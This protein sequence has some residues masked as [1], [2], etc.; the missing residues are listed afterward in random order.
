MK[1]AFF[2]R[3]LA[4]IAGGAERAVIALAGAMAERGHRVWIVTHE[5]S[6]A[7]P[8]YPVPETV[9]LVRLGKQ[10]GKSTPATPS[11]PAAKPAV[12]AKPKRKQKRKNALHVAFKRWQTQ[13]EP[14]RRAIWR[15]RNQRAVRDIRHWVREARPD[16][17][18]AFL[19][20]ITPHLAEAIRPLDAPSLMSFRNEPDY[21][22]STNREDL[23][24]RLRSLH[25]V[26]CMDQ[27]DR[28]TVLVP[29]YVDQL[30]A[31]MRPRTVV[32]PNE[33]DA[34]PLS[35][36][37][38]TPLL[39]RPR[40]ILFVG[41][42]APQKR[43][44]LLMDAFATIAAELPD[45]RV[46]VYGEGGE[47]GHLR[48]LVDQHGLSERVA[49]E[50]V[51][52]DMSSVYASGQ[53]LCA[54]SQYEGFP[55]ALSEGMAAGLACVGFSDCIGIAYLLE[56]GAGRLVESREDERVPALAQA[57]RELA[58]SDRERVSLGRAAMEKISGNTPDVV[59]DQWESVFK[60]MRRAP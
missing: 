13:S 6:A 34:R 30:P 38:R 56:G 46:A 36:A 37:Q 1:I 14:L 44:G 15:L 28:L 51:S 20:T 42:L 43:P 7:A 22:L 27:F 16:V 47:E 10:T 11:T 55:R 5:A 8:H 53:I 32:I 39:D 59:F 17:V 2:I 23:D 31:D 57:L 35:R 40:R 9:T 24:A 49:F 21:V 60:A 45:W 50:G 54:P 3:N 29:H 41:R 19:P 52:N 18:V 48:H 33:V 12:T 58:M 4:G 26:D 25:L